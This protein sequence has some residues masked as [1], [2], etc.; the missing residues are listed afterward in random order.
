[1]KIRLKSK[2]GCDHK[3]GYAPSPYRIVDLW[4]LDITQKMVK[5][6]GMDWLHN[7]LKELLTWDRTWKQYE[8]YQII[9][10]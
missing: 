10:E 7:H 2:Y 6:N 3:S 4:E 5:E 1:M 9:E 8:S